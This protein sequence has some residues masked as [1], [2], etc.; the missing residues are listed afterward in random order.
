MQGRHAFEPQAMASIDLESFVAEDHFLRQIDRVLDLKFVRE[1]TAAC[2][3]DGQGRPSIDPEVFFR[4]QLVAYFYG[5]TT[6]RRLC[7]EVRYNLA[8]RWF[9]RLALEDEVPDHSSASATATARA[10]SRPSSARSSRS[11]SRRGW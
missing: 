11:A 7:E 6:D 9:C 10:F 4:M 1:L 5:I 8:Y 2:Y 3:A